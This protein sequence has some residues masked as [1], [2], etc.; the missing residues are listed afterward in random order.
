MRFFGFLILLVFLSLPKADAQILPPDFLCIKGD[1]LIWDIPQNN[2]GPFVSYLIYIGEEEEGPYDLLIEIF[3]QNQTSYFPPNLGISNFYFYIESNF[4]CPGEMVL[5]SDTLDNRPLEVAVIESV[6]VENGLVQ[7]NWT[8]SPS[9]EV[10]GYIIYRK[11]PIGVIPVDTVFNGLSYLD[12]N[13][14]PTTQVET[15]FVNALDPCGNISIFD[16]PHHSMLLDAT[17]IPCAQTIIVNW[18]LYES[19]PAGIARHEIWVEIN[20]A[21]YELWDVAPNDV[22]TYNIENL[23]DGDDICFFVKAVDGSESYAANSNEVCF[24]LSLVNPVR[25]FFIKNLSVTPDNEVEVTW[26][27]NTNAELSS[28]QIFADLDENNLNSIFTQSASLPLQAEN[29]FVDNI[30]NPSIGNVFYQIQSRDICDTMEFTNTPSTIFLM[31]NAQQNLTNELS[32]TPL[33]IENTTDI[34]YEIFK[35]V[36]GI[37]TNIAEI[38]HPETQ[39]LDEVDGSNPAE[40]EACYYI[41]STATVTL[42]NGTQET[43]RSRSNIYCVQQF[44]SIL[45]PNAFVPRG[46]NREFKPRIFFGNSAQYQMTIFNR[47]GQ[48]I[49]ESFD[50]EIG[51]N[52]RFKGNGEDLPQGGYVYFI[53][54]TQPDGSRLER[55]GVVMLMR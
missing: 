27:W 14:D 45:V 10:F 13:S 26:S 43:I 44:A 36:G 41:L 6:S 8:A 31:G 22:N 54:L 34:S 18:N 53:E 11:T 12:L 9:P 40:A 4:D 24:S 39:Y 50:M 49:F 2:C 23:D 47:Y 51:W 48:I 19:W 30:S 32:W 15:Y 42:P 55:S 29:V 21:G 38:F 16:N 33:D 52:G 5:Q 46:T 20:G 17:T 25:N 7:L 28:Y 3:D 35:I 37:E 1:T